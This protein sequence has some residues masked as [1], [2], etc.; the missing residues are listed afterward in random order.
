MCVLFTFLG[1]Q[2]KLIQQFKRSNCFHLFEEKRWIDDNGLD[3]VCFFADFGLDAE[4]TALI[5]SNVLKNVQGVSDDNLECFLNSGIEAIVESRQKICG[6]S[7]QARGRLSLWLSSV[8]GSA[9]FTA[10]GIWMLIDGDNIFTTFVSLLIIILFGGGMIFS[11]I[12][13]V[14]TKGKY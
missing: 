8:G 9:L 2:I 13:L 12:S 11:I 3:W 6:T 4:G 14:S 10:G 5:L 1:A 7:E